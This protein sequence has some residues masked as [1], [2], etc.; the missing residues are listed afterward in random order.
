[1]KAL[2]LIGLLF[3]GCAATVPETKVGSAATRTDTTR[4]DNAPMMSTFHRRG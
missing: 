4:L 1:M 2:A 3:A